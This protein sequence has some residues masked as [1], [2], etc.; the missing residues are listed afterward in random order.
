MS[1][2][3]RLATVVLG[4]TVTLL[5]ATASSYAVD[6]PAP[7]VSAD[8]SETPETPEATPETTPEAPETTP[9]ETPDATPEATPEAPA[10]TVE[11]TPAPADA[12][13]AVIPPADIAASESSVQDAASKSAATKAAALDARF[14]LVVSKVGRKD[15]PYTYRSGCPVG[16]S[17]L[18]ML[19]LTH[20][21]FD[22]KDHR[23]VIVV[24]TS[25]VNDI[26]AVFK[27][28]LADRFP[29]RLM[30][31]VDRY[32]GSDIRSMEKDNTSA[33]NCRHVTGNPSRLSQHSYGNAVDVNTK[34]NPYVTGSRV[35]PASSRT[36]LNRGNVRKGM[37]LKSGPIPKEFANRRW[38]WG[39]R[40]S[41]PD[42]QHF[43]SNGK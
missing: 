39:A 29:I 24:R 31:P 4:T 34:E 21:G 18:R 8:P 26:A 43:S 11:P 17:G 3:R 13:E 40:W 15:L 32:K 36:Y 12:P 7:T 19:T 35:Y 37:L 28:A 2:R 27:R 9:S 38:F 30:R 23:G 10:A 16:P 6:E 1:S 33:F 5:A 41:H 20:I 22:K 14:N 42:Y 25:E